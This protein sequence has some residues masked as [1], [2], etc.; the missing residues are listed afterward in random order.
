MAKERI[1]R[2]T[3]AGAKALATNDP[4]FSEE[5]RRILGMIDGTH[6]DVLRTLL[7][8]HSDFQRLAELEAKGLIA[9]EAAAEVHDLDFTSSYGLAKP[10]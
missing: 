3:E 9:A 4:S 2:R 10:A 7:R 5:H 1:Y 8:Q 6:S